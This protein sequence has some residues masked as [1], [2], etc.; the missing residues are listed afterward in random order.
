[1]ASK[2]PTMGGQKRRKAT[3]SGDRIL[4]LRGKGHSTCKIAQVSKIILPLADSST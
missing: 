3:A 2:K 1:M 4:A